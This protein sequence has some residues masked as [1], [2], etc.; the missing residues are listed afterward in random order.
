MF[1]GSQFF[2][3]KRLTLKLCP[4]SEALW[5][6]SGF[7]RGVGDSGSAGTLCGHGS[8]TNKSLQCWA[9]SV[10]SCLHTQAVCWVWGVWGEG[11]GLTSSPSSSIP[12]RVVLFHFLCHLIPFSSGMCYNACYLE[13]LIVGF[14]EHT[15]WI[16]QIHH[17]C[18]SPSTNETPHSPTQYNVS[19]NFGLQLVTLK[20]YYQ[21]HTSNKK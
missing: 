19:P 20:C 16:C 12:S 8:H 13:Q 11:S 2:S 7:L 10:K 1:K 3:L 5:L 6:A 4:L 18:N 15:G 9:V 17:L 21:R 14:L